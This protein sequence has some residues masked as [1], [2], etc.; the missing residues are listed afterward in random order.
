MGSMCRCSLHSDILLPASEKHRSHPIWQHWKLLKH[1][2]HTS[3]HTMA[4]KLIIRTETTVRQELEISNLYHHNKES[5]PTPYRL[6][7]WKGSENME[8]SNQHHISERSQ[9]TWVHQGSQHLFP[10]NKNHFNWNSTFYQNLND[11]WMSLDERKKSLPCWDA[12]SF[13][14]QLDCA[15]SRLSRLHST[16]STGYPPLWGLIQADTDPFARHSCSSH[17]MSHSRCPVRQ[18]GCGWWGRSVGTEMMWSTAWAVWLSSQ[19]H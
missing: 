5:R 15:C 10:V 8:P 9:V 6:R 13:K 12:F 11:F 14:I 2:K 3:C 4:H 17:L 16:R 19:K 1:N 7:H 18:Q